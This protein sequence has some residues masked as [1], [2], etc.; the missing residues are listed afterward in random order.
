[1]LNELY[2]TL[3]EQDRFSDVFKPISKEEM[4]KRQKERI[5]DALKE[6]KCTLNPDGT[7]S[8]E[9]DVNLCYMGLTKIP[10]KFKEVK[11]SFYCFD[12]NLETLEGAPESVGGHFWCEHNNLISLK[13]APESV[14]GD[15]YFSGNPIADEL[16]VIVI[17]GSELDKYR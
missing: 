15:F 10:V 7:Y 8:C 16:G 9:G 14:G 1:M 17:K 2:N 11:R 3:K 13:G 5:E 12:N 4:K 6:G